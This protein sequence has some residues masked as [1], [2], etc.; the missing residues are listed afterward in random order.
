MLLQRGVQLSYVLMQP[1]PLQFS[2]VWDEDFRDGNVH[3]Q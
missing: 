2:L 3:L 1:L